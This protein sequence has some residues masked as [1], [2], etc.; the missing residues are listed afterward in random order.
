[1]PANTMPYQVSKTE[2]YFILQ[3]VVFGPYH[4]EQEANTAFLHET[5]TDTNCKECQDD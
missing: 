4:N 1:M 5:G 2:W 3:G